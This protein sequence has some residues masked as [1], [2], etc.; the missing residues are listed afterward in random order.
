[1]KDIFTLRTKTS[2]SHDK[3]ASKYAC[4]FR[5]FKFISLSTANRTFFE[6]VQLRKKILW[7]LGFTLGFTLGF[8]KLDKIV[9]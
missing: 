6:H 7:M 1:M 4:P 8:H 9:S 5:I 3:R 2:R